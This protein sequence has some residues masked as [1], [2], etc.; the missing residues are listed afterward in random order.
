MYNHIVSLY[1]LLTQSVGVCGQPE[2][3]FTTTIEVLGLNIPFDDSTDPV[4]VTLNV[5]D[6]DVCSGSPIADVNVKLKIDHTFVGDLEIS[7]SH[8][9]KS[10]V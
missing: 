5:P 7:L 8:D 9:G 10:F 2:Q 3:T 6:E 1:S 4:E